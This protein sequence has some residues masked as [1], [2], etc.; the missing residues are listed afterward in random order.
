MRDVEAWGRG[1]I[2]SAQAHP[3]HIAITR[4]T[5][6]G[7]NLP[8]LKEMNGRTTLAML[9]MIERYSDANGAHSLPQGTGWMLARGQRH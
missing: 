3:R 4:L 5:E 2:T 8:T 1:Q 7:I 6:A 9:A